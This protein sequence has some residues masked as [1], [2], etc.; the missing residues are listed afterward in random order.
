MSTARKM[1]TFLEQQGN[2]IGDPALAGGTNHYGEASHAVIRGDQEPSAEL[3]ALRQS[4][5]AGELS[6]E[7]HPF[8]FAAYSRRKLAQYSA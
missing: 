6:G 2:G 7:P 1:T 5:I 8:D 3:Q 4:L